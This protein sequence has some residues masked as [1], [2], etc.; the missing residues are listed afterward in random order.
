MPSSLESEF[1]EIEIET[2]PDKAQY[3]SIVEY[4]KKSSKVTLINEIIRVNSKRNQA[5]CIIEK[6]KTLRPYCVCKQTNE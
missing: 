6:D 1:H 2:F 4:N 5:N 3:H